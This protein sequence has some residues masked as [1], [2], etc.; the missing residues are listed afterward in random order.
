MSTVLI[1]SGGGIKSAVAAA[2][3]VHEHEIILLHVDYGHPASTA[4]S[5]ALAMLAAHWPKSRLC[6]ATLPPLKHMSSAV[7]AGAGT[8]ASAESPKKQTDETSQLLARRGLLPTMLSLAAQAAMRFGASSVVV[9]LS[10]HA[11]GEHIGLPGLEA[12]PDACREA[13]HAFDILLETLLRPRT[14]IRVE[15]P[16]IDLTYPQMIKLGQRLEVPWERT[17]TC[18]APTGGPC[19]RCARCRSRAQAFLEAAVRDTAIPIQ[20]PKTNPVAVK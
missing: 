12:G 7:R 19:G 9:G 20:A 2:R 1:L 17:I 3:Y 5:R 10:A 4:E 8:V 11:S 13:L 14:R 15:A 18:E 16:L 6:A